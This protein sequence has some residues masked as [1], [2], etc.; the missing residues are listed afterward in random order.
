[1]P[2]AGKKVFR[3]LLRQPFMVPLR[4]TVLR[5]IE[6]VFNMQMVPI[7]LSNGN[8]S[9]A[10][11]VDQVAK[12]RDMLLSSVEAA[13][14]YKTARSVARIPGD[15]AEVGVYRGASSRIIREAEPHKTFHL[16]DTF[17][18]LPKPSDRD[19]AFYEGLYRSSLPDVQRY[20][21]RYQGLHFYKGLFPET[22][23]PVRDLQFS[24]VHLD[25]DLYESTLSGLKFFWPRLST[26]GA[27]LSHDYS[28]SPGVKAAFDEFFAARAA[29]VFPLAHSQ[30]LVVRV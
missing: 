16:F 6:R 30:C 13:Q 24:F 1:M 2:Q 14:I 3:M 8:G 29:P 18:G 4:R 26:C 11:L 28:T 17:E 7:E 19:D 27:I 5:T 23:G 10:G 21:E 15:I 9:V 12:E 20:L 22:A 25:V